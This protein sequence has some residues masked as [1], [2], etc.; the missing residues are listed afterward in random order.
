MTKECLGADALSLANLEFLIIDMK[1]DSKKRSILDVPESRIS[2][3]K[4]LASE[5][6]NNRLT[7][8][9]LKLVLY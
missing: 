8:C 2:L 4:L 7:E 5:K 6:V 1:K 9:R 3:F